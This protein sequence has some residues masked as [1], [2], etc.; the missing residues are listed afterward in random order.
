MGYKWWRI[1]EGLPKVLQAVGG[2][3]KGPTRLE[4]EGQ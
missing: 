4:E 3:T 2:V 1:E